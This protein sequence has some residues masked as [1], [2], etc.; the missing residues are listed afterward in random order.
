MASHASAASWGAACRSIAMHARTARKVRHNPT[1]PALLALVVEEAV[2]ELE[3][4]VPP[5]PMHWSSAPSRS[6]A[7]CR[8]SLRTNADLASSTRGRAL[9]AAAALCSAILGV[10]V[11]GACGA[12]GP[13][14]ICVGAAPLKW[15]LC[16]AFFSA[17]PTTLAGSRAATTRSTMSIGR[18]APVRGSS[19][20]LV[21][22]SSTR[23]ACASGSA[24]NHRTP[25]S[26]PCKRINLALSSAPAPGVEFGT[27]TPVN[28]Q[29]ATDMAL[30]SIQARSEKPEARSVAS[31]STT[32]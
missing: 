12:C 21:P 17:A 26:S 28:T 18:R 11:C 27:G 19:A 10:V 31:S 8:R 6:V 2:V 16:E 29:R 4:V 20:R 15:R 9:R 7:T 22:S 30:L 23:R 24:A 3:D 5:P 13:S 14:S 32:S 1:S 25:P